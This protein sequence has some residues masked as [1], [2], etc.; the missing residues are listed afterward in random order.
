MYKDV[1]FESEKAAESHDTASKYSLFI[2]NKT[3]EDKPCPPY[4][5]PG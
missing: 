5:G 3:R 4:R 1:D 2:I